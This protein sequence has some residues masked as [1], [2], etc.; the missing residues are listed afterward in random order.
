MEGQIQRVANADVADDGIENAHGLVQRPEFL[1]IARVI[2]AP[3]TL[4]RDPSAPCGLYLEY[5]Y[6]SVLG[7]ILA[8]F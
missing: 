3:L 7:I 8:D 1:I 4:Q 5:V 2:P 6:N